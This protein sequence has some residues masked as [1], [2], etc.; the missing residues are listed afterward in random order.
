MEILHGKQAAVEIVHRAVNGI[1]GAASCRKVI[2]FLEKS[3]LLPDSLQTP[4]NGF[5][6][7]FALSPFEQTSQSLGELSLIRSVIDMPELLSQVVPEAGLGTTQVSHF[8]DFMQK[9]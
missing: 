5:S 6:E 8:D 1:A 4:F 7:L 3:R 9:A 2:G